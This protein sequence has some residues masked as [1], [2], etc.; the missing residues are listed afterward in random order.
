[1]L[2]MNKAIHIAS[3]NPTIKALLQKDAKYKVIIIIKFTHDNDNYFSALECICNCWC[4]TNDD[5]H[6]DNNYITLSSY[7][8]QHFVY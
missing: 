1:M 2:F 4:D 7:K 3:T 8:C 6:D 5:N